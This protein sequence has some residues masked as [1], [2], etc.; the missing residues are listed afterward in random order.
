MTDQL[1]AHDLLDEHGTKVG[2]VTDVIYDDATQSARYLVV[3]TGRFRPE[4]YVPT[5]RTYRTD[6]GD[7]VVECDRR[8]VNSAP[9]ARSGVA[10]QLDHGLEHEIEQ[11]YGL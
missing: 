5:A 2:K 3:R 7:V 10:H 11:H 8:L 1:T 9:R 6:Y 4:R